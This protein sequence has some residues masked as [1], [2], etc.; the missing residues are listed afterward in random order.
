MSGKHTERANGDKQAAGDVV[1]E[2]PSKSDGAALWRIARDSQKLDLN[3][4]Y[5]YLLWCNDFADTSVVARVDGEVVGF[6]LGYRRPSRPESGLVWQ[7]AVDA[8]QRGRGLAGKLLDALFARLVEE[9]VRYLDTTITPDNEASIRLFESFAKR[10]DA[11]LERSRLFAA[12]DFPDE[13]EPED[14]FRIGPLVRAHATT[15]KS[16]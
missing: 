11:T 9:G 5:A 14:L 7:V 13:H 16:T 1:I 3:S 6:V 12:G 15:E 4:S 10:W 8:S 2:S